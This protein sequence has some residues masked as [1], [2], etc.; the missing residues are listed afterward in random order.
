MR[1]LHHH[2]ES[3]VT[4]NKIGQTTGDEKNDDDLQSATHCYVHLK[5]GVTCKHTLVDHNSVLSTTISA[6]K[7]DKNRKIP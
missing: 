2:T 1:P 6:N 3:R 5:I 7:L 4:P